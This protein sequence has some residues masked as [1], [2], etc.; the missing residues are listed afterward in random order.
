MAWLHSKQRHCT[1]HGARLR[2]K[3][4]PHVAR[5][6]MRSAHSAFFVAPTVDAP[7]LSPLPC[8]DAMVNASVKEYSRGCLAAPMATTL[9]QL[10]QEHA[11]GAVEPHQCTAWRHTAFRHGVGGVCRTRPRR[12]R[13][14]MQC[15]SNIKPAQQ[16]SDEQSRRQ[17]SLCRPCL[18]LTRAYGRIWVHSCTA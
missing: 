17:C 1:L 7:P 14:C 11:T 9:F 8:N 18:P 16:Y 4:T 3:D 13:H 15:I 6:T 12:P 10:H 5:L 2:A